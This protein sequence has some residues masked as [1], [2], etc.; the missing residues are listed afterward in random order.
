MAT[1]KW[2]C[3]AAKIADNLPVSIIIFMI[4]IQRH[5]IVI[6]QGHNRYDAFSFFDEI[7]HFIANL[8][9]FAQV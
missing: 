6:S 1:F 3:I 2:I 4:N 8:Y 9:S 7:I 5:M